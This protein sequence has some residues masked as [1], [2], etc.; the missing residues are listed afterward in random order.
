[1]SVSRQIREEELALV[2]RIKLLKLEE[3]RSEKHVAEIAAKKETLMKAKERHK[4][5]ILER[6][7]IRDAKE[8]EAERMRSLVNRLKENNVSIIMIT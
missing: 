2:N 4:E 3:K 5:M 1:M 7:K 6:Q 8:A